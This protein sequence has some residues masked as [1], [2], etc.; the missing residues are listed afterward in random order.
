MNLLKLASRRIFRKGEHSVARIIS[1]T[2]G[3]AFGILLLSEVFYN[4]SYDSFYPDANRIY[5]VY[6]NFKMDKSSDKLESYGR[7]SGAVASGLKAEVPGIEVASRINSIGSSVFYTDDLKSYKAD[8]SLADEFLFDILPRPVIVGNPKEILKTP[9]NCMVSGKIADEMGGNVV[10]KVIE[11]KEYPNKKVTIA[12]VFQ[13]LPEN[14]NYHYDILVSMV[15]TGQFTWDGTNNWLG[16]DR[17]YTCVKLAPGIE[18]ESL[19]PAVR[20]MQEKYQDIIKLEQEQKGLVL[21][22]S[23]NP[24]KEIHANDVKD[25]III[26]CTIAFAVLFVSL[27]NYILLTL[28]SLINRAKTSAI[29]KCC[30]AE[31]RNLQYLIFSET[32]LLFLVSLAVA[33]LLILVIKP[34]AEAQ[35]GHQLS[36]VLNP[37]VLWPLLLLMVLL[38]LCL[39]YLPGRFFSRIPVATAFREY[40]QK[41]SKWKQVLLSFQFIGASFILTVL[42]FV[43]LQYNKMRH[44]DHGYRTQ[45]VYFGLTS[46]MNGNKISTLLNKLK[47]MPELEIVGLGFC[48]PT[49]GASGNNVLLPDQAKELFNI[50]DFYWIDENYLKV[51]NIPVIEGNDFSS[52]S[53]VPYN[54]LI[55]H[56]GEQ[57]LMM[58]TSWNDGILGKQITITEH[59]TATIQGVFP[60]FTIQS[61]A[62]PDTRPSVF[63][64]LPQ[65]KIEELVNENPSMAFNVI[66]K[67]YDGASN[68]LIRKL[69]DVFNQQLPHQDAVI[70]SLEDE[71]LNCYQAER[72]F[73]NALMAGNFIILL[74]SAIGL[75]GYTTNEATRRSKELAIRRISGANLSDILKMFVL[76]LEYM[77]IPAVMIGLTGAWITTNRWMSNFAVKIPLHW[78]V[79]ALC[80]IFVLLLVASIAVVNYTRMANRNPIEALRY[81]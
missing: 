45:D 30:G 2:L 52:G 56:K 22:Y 35:M 33:A 62:N 39:G 72:G 57:M 19:M 23:F 24:I 34:I 15:S 47:T 49:E 43:T 63:F 8:F 18:P 4:Y 1:L 55:S 51:L 65:E 76:D 10:G 25:M 27:L 21:K 36:S 40:R 5:V 46:G 31:A 28:S 17:Y 20:K 79:F 64:Y 38:V 7:V 11:L 54:I 74:I 67:A 61:M 73:R 44:A 78:G 12:G 60:D 69:T 50:A 37:Y 32:S 6:E 81:E 59:G 48:I 14:T 80:N 13:T 3:L 41:R 66:M 68:G 53:T 70:K 58:N 29:Y 75:L 42:V 9:M 77:A 26:L 71:Q 16:N